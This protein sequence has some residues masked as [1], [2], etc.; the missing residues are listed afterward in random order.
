M[1]TAVLRHL[2]DDRYALEAAA[3]CFGI[4]KTLPAQP[5]TVSDGGS[6]TLRLVMLPRYK[7]ADGHLSG[8]PPFTRVVD[9]VAA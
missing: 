6:P 7:Q 9:S 3:L 8:A 4:S 5:K 2:D 1:R